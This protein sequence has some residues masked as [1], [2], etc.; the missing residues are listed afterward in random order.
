M[1]KLFTWIIDSGALFPILLGVLIIL[2][3]IQ[4]L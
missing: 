3:L 2:W 1:K 4:G